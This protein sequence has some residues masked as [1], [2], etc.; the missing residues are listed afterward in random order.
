MSSG[1]LKKFCLYKQEVACSCPISPTC[2]LLFLLIVDLR[3][4]RQSWTC[5][6]GN[7]IGFWI[8][9]GSGWRKNDGFQTGGIM[10]TGGST[11]IHGVTYKQSHWVCVMEPN[12]G[13]VQTMETLT[14]V[15][16]LRFLL[17]SWFKTE[18]HSRTRTVYSLGIPPA[19]QNP[20]MT[21]FF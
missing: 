14:S 19:I 2:T 8:E 20:D 12:N 1:K 6:W 16:Q 3:T 10:C 15:S 5:S 18:Q 4:R 11:G 17:W 7:L 21:F 13:L 9:K